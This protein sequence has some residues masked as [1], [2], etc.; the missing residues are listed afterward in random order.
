MKIITSGKKYIDIDAYAGIIAYKHLLVSLS[1]EAIAVSSAAFNESI[2]SIIKDIKYKLDDISEINNQKFIVLD[3]SNPDM[4]DNIIDNNKIIEIIDHHTG[5]EQ[6]WQTKD[7]MNV[8]IEFI[9]SI[10]TIIFEK[11]QEYQ[12]LELLN[13][14]ICKLLIAGILDNT[15]NLKAT[16][17]TKRDI[18]AYNSLLAIGNIDKSWGDEYFLSCQNLIEQDLFLAIKNDLKIEYVSKYLPEV[19]G[20][21]LVLNKSS[22]LK[23]KEEIIKI[24]NTYNNEWIF[25]LI[26]LNDGKSYIISN[27]ELAKQKLEKLFDLKFSD[28]ILILEKFMLRK[29]IIKKARD[30]DSIE[31]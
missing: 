27:N 16:I 10:C 11:Y 13:S 28:G 21:L 3:V 24:M 7:N 19:F 15:L 26:C 23:R 22:I 4:F 1:E 25:N 8:Q 20:Q 31:V 9:G 2:S 17:T 5:F 14:D 18:N 30:C 6:Y 12:K 29:E